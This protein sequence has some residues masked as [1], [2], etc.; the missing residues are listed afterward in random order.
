MTVS[1]NFNGA[2]PVL[3]HVAH[4][5]KCNVGFSQLTETAQ[6][7]SE[8]L[9]RLYELNEIKNSFKV[10]NNDPPSALLYRIE[11]EKSQSKELFQGMSDVNRHICHSLAHCT[12]ETRN[13]QTLD[14]LSSKL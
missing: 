10:M 6:R 3:E 1:T 12:L 14:I 9:F 2:T 5:E 4:C 11:T 13:I 7:A 8:V